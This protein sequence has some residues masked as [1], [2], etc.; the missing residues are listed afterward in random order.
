MMVTNSVLAAATASLSLLMMPS[1]PFAVAVPDEIVDL[2][3]QA[4]D[5][6]DYLVY[7]DAPATGTVI[8]KKKKSK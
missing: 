8:K 5:M 6:F 2:N 1:S 7:S 3:E 4:F